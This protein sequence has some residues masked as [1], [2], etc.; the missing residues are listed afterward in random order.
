LRIGFIVNPIAG[1]GGRVGLKGTDGEEVLKEALAR[2]ATSWAPLRAR[3]TLTRLTGA[4]SE[5]EWITWPGEMGEGL[6]REMGFDHEVHGSIGPGMTTA[7]DTR[8][9]A[10]EMERL[11]VEL[12]LFAGGDGTASDIVDVVGSRV[13]ILG[14]P[15]G[16]KMFSAV[17]S[18]TPSAAAWLVLRFLSGEV[19]L[20]ERVVMDIDEEAYRSGRLSA[21]LKGYAVTP[22]VVEMVLGGKSVA[23]GADE[24]LMKEAV[25]SRVVEEMEPG[26]SYVLGPGSTLAKVAE[27]MG[28][29]KT[30]LGID[31]VRDGEVV[32]RD[33]DEEGLLDVVD[34]DTWIVLSP[35]GGQGSLLGRGNQ[36]ISPRVLRRVGL[37]RLIVIATPTKLLGLRALTVDTGDPELDQRLR[38]Y[39]RVIVGYREEKVVKVV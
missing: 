4:R 19:E 2:G 23:F 28:V 17:F 11:G 38:G 14:I 34:G 13:P 18:R 33:A 1:M 31:V 35:L 24:G 37:E 6:L 9:A 10:V 5:I 7:Q 16:V 3:E 27:V 15:S 21:T 30:I 26:V 8:E 29:E 22:Y 20:V 25:A 12:I 32:L 39:R 36:P